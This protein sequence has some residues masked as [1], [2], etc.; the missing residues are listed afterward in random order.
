MER[1]PRPSAALLGRRREC[2]ALD[3]L[4]T[5]VEG[6]LSASLLIHGEAGIGKTALLHY[7]RQKAETFRVA[8]LAGIEAEAELAFGGL[9]QLCRP[10]LAHLPGLPPPQREALETAFG[11]RTGTPPDRFLVGLAT[12][13]LLADVAAERPLLCQVDDAQWL[14]QVSAQTLAFVGRRLS[15]ERVLLLAAMRDPVAG[16]PFQV[17][18]QEQL[19]GLDDHDARTLLARSAPGR[20]DE[21]VRERVL[22][23]A[24]G[25]PL[26][27]LELPRTATTF[28]VGAGDGDRSVTGN[29]VERAFRRR[30]QALSPDAQR[31]L[32]LAAA[33]PAGDVSQ[34]RLAAEALHLHVEVAAAEAEAADLLTVRS[35][36]RFRHP[37]VRSAAYHSA[38]A[39]ERRQVHAAL[40]A[41]TDPLTDP[42]RRAWHLAN[43]TAAADERVAAGLEAASGRAR[44]RGGVA[45]AA[46]FLGRAA[47][48][49]AD[50]ER[51]GRR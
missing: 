30:L 41:A 34:L 4:I 24:R 42:D 1:S 20:V 19:T 25:N 9:H 51:R 14:D 6:G 35:M 31:F 43:A 2:A 11:L 21:R 7:V 3:E 50:P 15:A 48:L 8:R 13:G 47:E 28:T 44:A 46:A 16:H 23:E 22:A 29:H 12:L 26:A 27:L 18:P 38:S 33:D 32:L 39:A 36:V 45:A 49:T 37:L 40:A 10:F 17:L 5:S